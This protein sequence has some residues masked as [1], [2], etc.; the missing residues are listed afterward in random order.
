[1][2]TQ[3]PY[4]GVCRTSADLLKFEPAG[5]AC[6]HFGTPKLSFKSCVKVYSCG[7]PVILSCSLS[8]Y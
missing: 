4:N 8:L 1:M 7:M 2:L 5:T 6:N 3:L